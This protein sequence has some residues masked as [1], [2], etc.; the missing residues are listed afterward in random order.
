MKQKLLYLVRLNFLLCIFFGISTAFA[1][2]GSVSGQISDAADGSLLPGVSVLIKGTS[3]GT[4]T[5]MDGKFTLKL[6][7]KGT[8]VISFIGYDA[9]EV[10]AAPGDNVNLKLSVKSTNLDEVLV[11]GYGTVKKSDATGSVA[12][13]TS[14]DFNKGAITSPQD[15]L[16]GKSAGVVITSSGG[17]PGS[18]STIRIR[19]GSSLSASNDPL[20]VIDGMPVDNNGVSGM[21]NPLSVV[22]PNDIETFTVLKDASA[23]AIYGSRA[24]NGVIIITTK[25]GKAGKG[26]KVSYDANLSIGTAIKFVDVYSGDEFRKMAYDHK[27]LYDV[28]SFS[29]LG[30]ENTNWQNEIFRTS[31]SSD[32]NIS[33]S[34]V[35]YKVPYRASIGYTNQNGILIN[36]GMQRTTASIGLDPVFLDGNLKLNI[37]AKGMNIKNNFGNE[38]AI[39]AAISMDP[40]KPVMNG[41]KN[42]AGYYTW[43]TDGSIDGVAKGFGHN[44][45]AMAT[46]PDNNSDVNRAIASVQADYKMPF[47]PELRANLN[48]A[49]DYSK[50]TG[51]NNVDTTASWMR[52]GVWGQLNNY[53][54][55][56]SN[57]LL[58]F[59]LNYNKEIG[60]VKVDLTGGYSWQHF[61]RE[62]DSY[63]RSMNDAAHPYSKYGATDSTSFATENYLVSFFSRLNLSFYNRY[64]FTA[65]VRNDGSSRFSSDNRWGLFR[66]GAFA[67]KAKDEFFLKDVKALSDLK[68]R[69]G[70]G[71]TG[72]Q[73]IGGDYPA[74]AQY[75]IS[76]IGYSYQFGNKFVNTLRPN[77]YDP[78][79]KWEK[80][81]T[82]NGGLDFG[83]F[84]DRI[85]GSVEIYK[86][87]TDDLLNY[88]AIPNGSNFSNYLT[89]NVGSLENK[90]YEVTLNV[91]PISKKDMELSI[92]FNL[93]YNQNKITKLS[94]NDDPN[95]YGAP[96]GTVG[97][98]NV[99]KINSVGY[100]ANSFWVN[101]QIYDVNGKPVEG[102]YA[103]LSGKGGD[104]YGISADKYHYKKAAPDY[105]MGL[106]ARFNYKNFD[107]SASSRISLGNYVYNA[108][109]AG[110]SY[111]I[112]YALDYWANA[113]KFLNETNFVTRQ[114]HSDYF[115]QDA[116]FFKLDNISCGY[117][118]NKIANGKI[119]ARLNFTVQNVLTVTKYKGLDP[120]VDGGIDNNF[121]PRPRTFILGVNLTF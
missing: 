19:G 120:E 97:M 55:K 17:A 76:Q 96:A 41:N 94:K 83:F 3:V 81:S 119:D 80:T 107:V 84:N 106:S 98:D 67:W 31:V 121:Y 16:V 103:D 111:D 74:Q 75:S 11:I 54:G 57:K 43:T 95:Y 90:G 100:P 29:K 102:V 104:V 59:Y 63:V 85:T 27:S 51:H 116:S 14:K 91:R 78:N 60:V 50:S 12:S 32:H 109:A 66:S 70:Y 82:L 20:I 87:T 9:K 24:S 23:T 72:Q 101:K 88:I 79:I 105:L 42:Y 71:E 1:Q 10:E 7:E 48:L 46:L 73:N 77:A 44:P 64:M 47:L 30:N 112:R 108:N 21:S 2:E 15:L 33:M 68:V 45:V 4:I 114:F 89:T 25:K 53:S 56:N 62:G 13:V 26:I 39:G 40:T 58:D 18:G 8:L 5:D 92:G 28:N 52:S 35:A 117:N 37:N 118:F 36:T 49:I 99:I 110:A 115:V 86:R 38:G 69:V 65:T 6:K 22:N 113:P 93:T 34:G 61:K